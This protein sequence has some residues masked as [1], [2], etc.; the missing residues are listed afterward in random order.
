MPEA[1]RN[2][3]ADEGTDPSFWRGN[4]M[5]LEENLFRENALQNNLRAEVPSRLDQGSHGASFS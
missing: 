5:R 4:L 1:S 3:V 2:R